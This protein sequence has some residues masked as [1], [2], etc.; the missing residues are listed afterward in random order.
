MQFI[1]F[2][3]LINNPPPFI[4]RNSPVAGG[5]AGVIANINA[6]PIFFT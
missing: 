4:F 2:L 1:T 5:G 3:C 6:P